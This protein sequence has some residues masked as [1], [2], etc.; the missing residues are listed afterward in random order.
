MYISL[1][2]GIGLG[3]LLAGLYYSDVILRIPV[4]MYANAVVL[5]L[6]LTYMLSWQRKHKTH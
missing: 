3:A 4:I 6:A 2:A 1:E 5:L